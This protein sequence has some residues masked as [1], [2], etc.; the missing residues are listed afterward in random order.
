M[1]IINKIIVFSYILFAP[2]LMVL[3]LNRVAAIIVLEVSFSAILLGGFL[4][5]QDDSHNQNGKNK[6]GGIRFG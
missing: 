3:Y 6:K 1:K 4:C 5:A 2:L